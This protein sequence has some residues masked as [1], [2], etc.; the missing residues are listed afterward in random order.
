MGAYSRS[1]NMQ[2]EIHL[3]VEVVYNHALHFLREKF[4]Y[5]KNMVCL[6]DGVQQ[7]VSLYM[8]D[9]KR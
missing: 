1:T 6:I 3:Y 8:T 2:H 4:P 5:P 7:V 9:D